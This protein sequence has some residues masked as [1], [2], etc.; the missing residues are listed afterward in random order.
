MATPVYHGGHGYRRGGYHQQRR[1]QS[2]EPTGH[3]WLGQLGSWLGGGTP[4]YAGQP[5][6][7]T[8][9]GGSPTYLPAPSSTGTTGAATTTPQPTGS[10]IVVPHS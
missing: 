3:G 4:T 5:T 6:G 1:G 10:V 8:V 2:P 9:R 7:G